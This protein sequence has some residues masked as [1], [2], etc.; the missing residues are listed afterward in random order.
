MGFAKIRSENAVY[1]TGNT[2]LEAAANYLVEHVSDAGL[3]LPLAARLAGKRPSDEIKMVLVVRQDLG[4]SI[5]KTAA[6]CGHAAV[7]LYRKMQKKHPEFLKRWEGLGEAKIVLQGKDEA[8]LSGL[9]AQAES[10]GLPWY[11]VADAG[12]TE[13]EP[14]TRTVLGIAGP[15]DTV[16]LVTGHLRLL[17]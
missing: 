3:D 1:L 17:K 7:A 2:T 10:L 14:G 8:Q 13:I 11:F 5:G 4:L 16:N 9:A 6:Q 15:V 12:R